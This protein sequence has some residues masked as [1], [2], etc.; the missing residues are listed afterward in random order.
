LIQPT[1]VR[2]PAIVAEIDGFAFDQF[3]AD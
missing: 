3:A 1:A 2:P